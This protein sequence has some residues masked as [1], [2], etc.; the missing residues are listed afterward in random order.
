V[1]VVACSH[2]P[3]TRY[4]DAWFRYVGASVYVTLR[5]SKGSALA[6][7]WYGNVEAMPVISTA[8]SKGAL[9]ASW[10]LTVVVGWTG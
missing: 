8:A 1:F 7:P 4:H 2:T 3:G 6:I 9:G 5:G 10:Q